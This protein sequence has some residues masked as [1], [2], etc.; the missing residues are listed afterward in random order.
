MNKDILE[1]VDLIEK[2]KDIPK[3]VMFEAIE[4][5]LHKAFDNH[6]GKR[7]NVKCEVNRETGDFNILVQKEVVATAE[8][9]TDPVAMISLVDA[10]LINEKAE[11]GDVVDVEFESKDFGR[12]A[13]QNAKSTILQTIREEEHR[14]VKNKFISKQKKIVTGV[15]RRFVG[16]RNISIDLGKA[17]G[18]LAENEQVPTERFKINDRIKVYVVDVKDSSKGPRINVSRTHPDLVKLLF[19]QEVAEVADGTVE[20][21]AIAREAG[22]RTKIAVWSNNEDVDPVGACVGMNGTRVTAINDELRGEKIDIVEWDENP[23]IF[24]ENALSPATVVFAFADPETKEAKVVVP[25]KQLSLAIGMN[26]QNAR[27]AARLTGYKIDIK[28]ETQAQDAEGFRLEDYEDDYDE[29][30]DS[31]N[32]EYAESYDDEAL[33]NIDEE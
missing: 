5:S 33:E 14:A 12:I 24:I 2:E 27:L 7:D 10:K 32:E 30:D 13:A 17:E 31:Y 26:G 23:G 22:S 15:V 1:A 8:E 6:F 4:N 20:I 28:S 11:V 16:D 9:V 19:E 29:Y 25:D 18:F 3:E 21:K